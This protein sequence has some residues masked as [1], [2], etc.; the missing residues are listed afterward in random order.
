MI[1]FL[2]ADHFLPVK[3]LEYNGPIAF[4]LSLCALVRYKD[5]CLRTSF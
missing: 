4:D 1:A 5:H 2:P 3:D